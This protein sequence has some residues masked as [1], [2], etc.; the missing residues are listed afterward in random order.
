MLAERYDNDQERG[1]ALGH[2]LSGVSV[3]LAIGPIFG[4]LLYHYLGK[5][6]PFLILAGLALIDG[7]K[8]F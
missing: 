4:G 5:P 7:S 6:A 2:A 1:K 3:G 8:L